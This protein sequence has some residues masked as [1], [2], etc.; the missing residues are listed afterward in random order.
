ML[1]IEELY[2]GNV[3]EQVQSINTDQYV[4]L[5]INK[6]FQDLKPGF[7]DRSEWIFFNWDPAHKMALASK[8]ATKDNKDG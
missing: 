8:D 5:N 7:K 4:H 1:D 2:L 6:H 3:E